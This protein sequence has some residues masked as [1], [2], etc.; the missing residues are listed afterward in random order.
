M[1]ARTGLTG[2]PCGVPIWQGVTLS[3]SCIGAR[4][5]SQGICLCT[6]PLKIKFFVREVLE[7]LLCVPEVCAYLKT[8][9]PRRSFSGLMEKQVLLHRAYML[10][11]L[12]SGLHRKWWFTL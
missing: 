12:C 1:L 5:F 2:P 4:V 10:V 9:R 11:I 8:C 6:E 3:S 7:Q